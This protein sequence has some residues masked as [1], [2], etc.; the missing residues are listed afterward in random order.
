MAPGSPS[1]RPRSSPTSASRSCTRTS[2][3]PAASRSAS[4]APERRHS[5]S[6]GDPEHLVADPDLVTR[7]QLTAAPLR[8]LAVEE[9]GVQG[10]E[11]ARLP[12]RLDHAG[13]L[14][15]LAE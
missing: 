13:E 14:E 10:E 15:Q 4:T 11:G 9:E 12:A 1:G 2:R 6:R 7:S 8:G 5:A 3:G